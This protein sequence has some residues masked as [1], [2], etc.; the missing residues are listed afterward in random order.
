MTLYAHQP[1][2]LVSI[3]T[4]HMGENFEVASSTMATFTVR[5]I[6]DMAQKDLDA[7]KILQ[8]W[9]Y[10]HRFYRNHLFK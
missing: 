8:I 10:W 4:T 9:Y 3:I 2:V 7:N 5:L 6:K 1:N